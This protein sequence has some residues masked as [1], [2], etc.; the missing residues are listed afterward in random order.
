MFIY[1]PSKLACKVRTYNLGSFHKYYDC[2]I[3]LFLNNM[4]N[5]LRKVYWNTSGEWYIF[6]IM[7]FD[8]MIQIYAQSYMQILLAEIMWL[9][10]RSICIII[11]ISMITQTFIYI[12][13]YNFWNANKNRS[14]MQGGYIWG[15]C[16]W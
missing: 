7:I 2:N 1:N 12:F 11:D 16:L 3:L 4:M 15:L 13:Y 10:I 6:D 14:H 8:I 9:C 5:V